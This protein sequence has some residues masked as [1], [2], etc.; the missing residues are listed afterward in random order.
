MFWLLTFKL[1]QVC[2]VISMSF[3]TKYLF[4]GLVTMLLLESLRQSHWLSVT[5]CWPCLDVHAIVKQVS[6]SG[7]HSESPACVCSP[8]SF[9]FGKQIG[10]SWPFIRYVQQSWVFKLQETCTLTSINQVNTITAGDT[11]EMVPCTI[12][13]FYSSSLRGITFWLFPRGRVWSLGSVS[14]SLTVCNTHVYFSAC[15]ALYRS[16]NWGKVFEKYE[17]NECVERNHARFW[18]YYFKLY[19][20]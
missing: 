6:K 20:K 16:F 2:V 7:W 3:L 12:H 18:D 17:N 4:T 1:P 9:P 8:E 5:H 11:Y 15:L 13:I 19:K 10:A 14:H